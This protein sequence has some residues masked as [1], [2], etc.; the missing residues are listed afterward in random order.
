MSYLYYILV[1]VS[2]SLWFISSHPLLFCFFPSSQLSRAS[3]SL[4][5]FSSLHKTFS[6]QGSGR[7]LLVLN[8]IQL[9]F[10]E[11]V[12]KEACK[13]SCLHFLALL[14]VMSLLS[15]PL[16]IWT[17]AETVLLTSLQTASSVGSA[18]PCASPPAQSSVALPMWQVVV[19][20]SSD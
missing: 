19:E 17:L 16:W 5:P 4:P 2:L 13:T 20:P 15:S 8:E 3:Q 12:A 11:N 6:V 1:P 14:S 10:F 18:A 7:I 9:F